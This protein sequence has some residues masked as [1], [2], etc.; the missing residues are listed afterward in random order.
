MTD[1]INQEIFLE[2]RN[3]RYNLSEDDIDDISE[4]LLSKIQKDIVDRVALQVE[5][6]FYIQMGKTFLNKILQLV[7]ITIVGVFLY[8]NSKGMLK[9]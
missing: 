6:R 8:L 1:E 7:G 4:R 3:L 2:R 9:L 5:E